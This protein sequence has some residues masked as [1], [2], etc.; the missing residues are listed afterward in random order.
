MRS[1]KRPLLERNASVGEIRTHPDFDEEFRKFAK[2]NPKDAE[3]LSKGLRRFAETRRGDVE[4]IRGAEILQRLKMAPNLP[5]VYLAQKGGVT[6]LLGLEKRKV[7]YA[8]RVLERMERRA[9]NS[10]LSDVSARDG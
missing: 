10:V 8:S 3:R 4:R 2:R 5:R 6:Y 7:A 1:T 9:K